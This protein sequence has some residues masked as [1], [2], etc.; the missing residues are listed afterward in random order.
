M[1]KKIISYLKKKLD[2][3]LFSFFLKK[4]DDL[5]LTNL[6]ERRRNYI[7]NYNSNDYKADKNDLIFIHIPKTGG[8]SI[9]EYLRMNANNYYIFKKKSNHNAVSLLCSP[10]EYNYITFLRDPSTR[11]F[12]YYNMSLQHK[13]TPAHSLAKKGIIN[14]LKYDY[15]V[16]NLYCQYFSGYPG[17]TIND[18]I[19]NIA[20]KNLKNFFYVG[21]F[22]KFSESFNEMCSALKIENKERPFINTSLHENLLNAD[23]KVLIEGYNMYDVK[24][25]NNFFETIKD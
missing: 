13:H 22:E 16:K 12:S 25:Y 6:D 4:I 7:F 23:D 18:E 14:L 19:Y 15:Q 8:A 20:L 24:L 10:E 3:K 1:I 17:E 2:R 9:D 11:V 5:S 21:K